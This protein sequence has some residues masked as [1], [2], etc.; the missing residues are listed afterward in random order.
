ME[1][2]S[3]SYLSE[4]QIR[5]FA[6]DDKQRAQDDPRSNCVPSKMAGVSH[7]VN[8]G[9]STPVHKH[10]FGTCQKVERLR[11]LGGGVPAGIGFDTPT[12]QGDPSDEV[13]RILAARRRSGLTHVDG[14]RARERIEI[15]YGECGTVRVRA[16][17]V[18]SGTNRQSEARIH[19]SGLGA[20]RN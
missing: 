9:F 10:G 1:V 8:G 16:Q 12:K 11:A 17:H 7:P 3:W 5:R 14:T 19:V 15:E 20:R 13:S 4:L 2:S 18:P 6:R